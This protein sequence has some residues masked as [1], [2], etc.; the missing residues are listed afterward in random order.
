MGALLLLLFFLIWCKTIAGL[1]LKYSQ[2]TETWSVG[3]ISNCTAGLDPI[4]VH[5]KH[6]WAWTSARLYTIVVMRTCCWG[7]IPWSVRRHPQHPFRETGGWEGNQLCLT[8]AL[9]WKYLLSVV[10]TVFSIYCWCNS[11]DRVEFLADLGGA[12]QYL[13]LELPAPPCPVSVPKRPKRLQILTSQVLLENKPWSL[14]FCL[15]K[16][17]NWLGKR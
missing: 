6:K 10:K 8:E 11:L 9:K 16:T 1:I 14:I 5:T 3:Q 12:G 15:E 17:S 2:L 13:A 4:L 7:A